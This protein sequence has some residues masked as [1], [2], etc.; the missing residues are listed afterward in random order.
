MNKCIVLFC[1]ISTLMA[2]SACTPAAPQI[3]YPRGD[4]AKTGVFADPGFTGEWAFA[5]GG[6]VFS[7]PVIVDGVVYIGS[8]DGYLY[9][10][11]LKSGQLKWKFQAIAGVGTTPAVLD[12][13]VYF[14][15]LTSLEDPIAN[16]ENYFYAVDIATGKEIWKTLIPYG[17]IST[18]VVTGEAVYF[19]GLAGKFYALNRQDGKELWTFQTQNGFVSSSYFADGVLYIGGMDAFLYALDAG[20]GEKKWAAQ[21]STPINSSPVVTEKEVLICDLENWL[22]VFDRRSGKQI[23]KHEVGQAMISS[24]VV[25]GE[26]VYFGLVDGRVIAVNYLTGEGIWEFQTN[27]AIFSSPA[28]TE[29]TVYIGSWDGNLYAVNRT[30]GKLR[31]KFPTGGQI[32]SSPSVAGNMLIFGSFDQQIY[33]MPVTGPSTALLPE[34]TPTMRPFQPTLTPLPPTTAVTETTT[35]GMPWWNDRVFYEVFVR[36]FYDSDNDGIG[37]LQ[38]LISKLDYLNDGDPNTTTDLGITGIWLMPVAQS[39]SY[40]GYDTTD[41]YTIEED[42]GTNAD[43]KQLMAEAHKRG[44]VVIVDLVMNHTSNQHPWFIESRQPGSEYEPWYIWS[45]NYVNFVSPWGSQVW[46][47]LDGRFYY[48]LFWSGMPDLNYQHGAVTEE[49]F[50]IIRYWLEDM[51]ADGFR[52]DAVRHLIEDGA[53]QENTP[54][55]HE[56]LKN[57]HKHVRSISADAVMVGEVWDT[58]E[59]V[60]KYIGDEVDLAFEFDL[61]ET[62]LRAVFSGNN[63]SLVAVQQGILDAFPRGQYAA[64]LTNHDQNRVLNSLRNNLDS[65]RAAAT[66]LLTNPGVPFIYYGEEIGM[67]G[68]KPD[69]LIRTPMQW[70]NSST[71]GF[72]VGTPWQPLGENYATNNVQAMN[73]DANSLLNHYRR[74]IHLR[75]AHPALRTGEMILVESGSSHVYSFLRYSGEEVLLVVV[76]LSEDEVTDYALQLAAG[77]LKTG[78]TARLALGTGVAVAPQVTTAGGFQDYKPL[79][80]LAAKGSY[81]IELMP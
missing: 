3:A 1:A 54:A 5:T 8:M 50:A 20:T 17:L 63:T 39:P 68:A 73:R 70:S 6:Q 7:S 16:E 21:V 45:P 48:G 81:I 78:M 41:Y 43:F 32:W 35:D 22:Y 61:A 37:D 29:D 11:D 55:T 18:P 36:S 25:K 76:N 67:R 19:G 30:D 59:E 71:A 79:A 14:G 12:G 15:T 57:F 62:I 24:P 47:P 9:A 56:W 40:H 80:R 52:L 53:N 69:E 58:T 31:W 64:F 33:A 28:V 72:T 26:M 44:I 60:L 49:M 4:A 65:A 75:N 42:Y 66:I 77:P 27:N 23:A 2:A 34:P 46:H 13:K 51:G 38:G 74:L 10:I